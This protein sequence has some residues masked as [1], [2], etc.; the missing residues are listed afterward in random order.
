MWSEKFA[1]ATDHGFRYATPAAIIVMTPTGSG[2]ENCVNGY[3][4][5]MMNNRKSVKE[6][7]SEIQKGGTQRSF[8]DLM[9]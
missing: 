4:I 2:K 7:L 1:V 3:E 6:H 8:L 9:I 5:R